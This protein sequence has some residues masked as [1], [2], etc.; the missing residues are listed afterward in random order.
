MSENTTSE[1]VI[2][3]D[4]ERN[5]FVGSCL[6]EA[7]AWS[8]TMCGFKVKPHKVYEGGVDVYAIK[9]DEKK[10]N[11][12]WNWADDS[13]PEEERIQSI[14]KN[15]DD[16]PNAKR[17]LITANKVDYGEFKS[18]MIRNGIQVVTIGKQLLSKSFE[19]F[20]F[21]KQRLIDEGVLYFKVNSIINKWIIRRNVVNNVTKKQFETV[22]QTSL[23]VIFCFLTP[24]CAILSP[25]WNDTRF[26]VANFSKIKRNRNDR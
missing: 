14:I 6:E 26:S 1:L 5:N 10:V 22:F 19:N 20:S 18:R 17:I 23:T 15:F 13:Y 12:C 24:F 25:I 4:R 11:E 7:V 3:L 9:N 8:F 2:G 16:H 21:V